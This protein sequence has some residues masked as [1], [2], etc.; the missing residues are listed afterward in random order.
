MSNRDKFLLV[1]IGIA[2]VI[3]LPYFLYIKDTRDR[4]T[5]L[6]NE[7]VQLEARYNELLEIEKNRDMYI[8]G[9]KEYNEKRDAIIAKYPADIQQASYVMYLLNMEYSEY[10][11]RNN[12]EARKEYNDLEALETIE[13]GVRV[14]SIEFEE[15]ELTPISSQLL[16]TEDGENPTGAELVETEYIAVAN[17]S[18]L[19]FACYDQS[20]VNHM[21]GYIRDDEIYPMIY[22]EI[23][24][25]YDEETGVVEGEM[26]L[27]QYA[28][29]GGEG[30]EFLP[31]S[32]KP[33]ITD[34]IRG[35]D[36][37]G[38]FGPWANILR[39]LQR[40]AMEEAAN[41]NNAAND[42]VEN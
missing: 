33:E 10:V 29:T 32:V 25:K 34:D 5:N 21:L 14:H 15:N 1:I 22:R 9:T 13:P 28:V 36:E 23:S 39:Q 12:E 40:I 30:R 31:I 41:G 4:I 42:A 18:K 11:A 20:F 17:S 6:D 19:K 38:I 8:A 27:A 3:L 7:I 16:V 24:F 37:F 35:N 2:G 26:N